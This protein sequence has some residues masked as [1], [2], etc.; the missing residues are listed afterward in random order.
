MATLFLDKLTCHQQRSITFDRPYIKESGAIVFG[1]EKMV[2]GDET[3]VNHSSQH[4]DPVLIELWDHNEI[5]SDVQ[6]GPT[7]SV[8]PGDSGEL[9]FTEGAS[10]SLTYTFF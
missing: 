5:G 4:N 8:K 2:S 6:I 1:K 7:R 3:P 9:E 10:Y